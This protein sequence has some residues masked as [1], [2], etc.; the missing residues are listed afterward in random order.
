[1]FA[2]MNMTKV[3]K[4]YIIDV[5][6]VKRTQKNTCSLFPLILYI[7]A[8]HNVNVLYFNDA[9]FFL[10]N[11]S[12]CCC[13]CLY[14]RRMEMDSYVS[15]FVFFIFVATLNVPIVSKWKKKIFKAQKNKSILL[16]LAFLK[17]IWNMFEWICWIYNTHREYLNR[18]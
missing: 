3:I 6:W 13:C 7:V 5:W 2:I 9:L 12:F 10:Q 1:M 15:Q 11:R 4:T 16:L 14:K 8:T 18:G 17:S